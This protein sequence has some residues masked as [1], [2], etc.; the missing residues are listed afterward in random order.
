MFVIGG[1]DTV[2]LF[3]R[4]WKDVKSWILRSGI[5]KPD[6]LNT[7]LDT[8]IVEPIKEIQS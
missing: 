5:K 1:G 6:I 7:L 4:L 2:T 8:C 3:E